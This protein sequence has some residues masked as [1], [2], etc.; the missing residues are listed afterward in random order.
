MIGAIKKKR[1]EKERE[2]L[3]DGPR[4]RADIFTSCRKFKHKPQKLWCDTNFTG[5]SSVRT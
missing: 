5:F 4:R 2:T 1:G 3:L